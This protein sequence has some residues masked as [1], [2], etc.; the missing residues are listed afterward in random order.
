MKSIKVI[1]VTVN[2]SDKPYSAMTVRGKGF[3]I[4][5][6]F[7]LANGEA[8]ESTITANKKKDIPRAIE[9]HQRSA[10]AGAMT[11]EFDDDGKQWGVCMK[12]KMG[13]GGMVPNGDDKEE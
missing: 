6:M 4:R 12:W 11:M 13:A 9:N 1:K 2:P 7:H 5:A 3:A 10:E 8:A